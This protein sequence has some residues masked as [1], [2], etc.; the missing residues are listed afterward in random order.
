M[1]KQNDTSFFG[2]PRG[3]ATLFFTEMWERFSYYGMRALLILFMTASVNDGGLGF[4]ARLA[5]VVYGIY[6]A[7]V[8]MTNLPG[9]WFADR[10]I[11]ARKAVFVGGIII[12]LGHISLI[13]NGLFFFYFGLLLVIIGTGLLKPNVS[14]M[15]GDL[16]SKE[17]KR[18]DGGFSIFYMGINIG[19]FIAPLICGYLG[20]NVNWHYGFGMAAIG[21]FF[22]L[23]QY[24]STEKYLGTIGLPSPQALDPVTYNK[25]KRQLI[26][27]LGLFLLV[28]L[29]LVG[30]VY[31]GMVTVNAKSLSIFFGCLYVVLVFGYFGAL[32][33]NKDLTAEERGRLNVIVV[34][35]LAAALFWA[36]YEQVGSTLNLFADRF[37]QNSILGWAFPS[38]WWQSVHAL[39]IIFLAPV[40][41]WIWIS[42]AKKNKEPSI[43]LKFSYGLLFA[44]FSFLI[45][46]PAALFLSTHAGVRVGPQ[47]LL[48]VFFLQTLGEL[49]LSPVGLSSMTKL[50]PPRIVGQM[51]GV[52]FLAASVGNFIGGQVGSLFETFP[53]HQIFLTVFA[54][55]GTFGVV[56]FLLRNKLK[57]LMGDNK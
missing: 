12:M 54:F 26:N 40:F 52:W 49:C 56:L 57:G 48:S 42:L 8:Y 27:G 32:F 7:L 43:P 51:M 13:F 55:A 29:S 18:R 37:T 36:S 6:T 2:Q 24:K 14:S 45:L 10:F 22:G 25:A 39:L 46:V 31:S 5:G 38:S 30:L 41:A 47:W 4:D 20:Q 9:G 17:D 33:S 15:V 44:G 28:V 19:A 50:A 16:Y 21:M 1:E 34:L 11:G 53:L 23:L 3:L 35:F